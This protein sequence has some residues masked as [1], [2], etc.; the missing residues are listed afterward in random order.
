MTK[1]A[2]I[3]GHCHNNYCNHM[4]SS[5]IKKKGFGIGLHFIELMNFEITNQFRQQSFHWAILDVS[6]LQKTFLAQM[7]L[8]TVQVLSHMFQLVAHLPLH[9]LNFDLIYFQLVSFYCFSALLS[10]RGLQPVPVDKI[11]LSVVSPALFRLLYRAV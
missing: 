2:S 1:I 8:M 6:C 10:R 4:W 11:F 9:H 3:F 7:S 5:L